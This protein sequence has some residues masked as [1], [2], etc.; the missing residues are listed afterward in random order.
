MPPKRAAAAKPKPPAKRAAKARAK[1]DGE[2]DDTPSH[3]KLSP[4]LIALGWE[5]RWNKEHSR[6]YYCTPPLDDADDDV[7][8][9]NLRTPS[10]RAG[11]RKPA[12]AAA[13]AKHC[14][15]DG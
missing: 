6:F 7:P 5:P 3:P 4:A 13:P 8:L 12:A 9:S 2:E 15:P 10:E 14:L 11:E 1:Q